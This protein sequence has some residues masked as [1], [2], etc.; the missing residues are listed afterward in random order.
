MKLILFVSSCKIIYVLKIFMIILM[1]SE[2]AIIVRN[3][4]HKT[5]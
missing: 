5:V 3:V 1:F 2:E 4:F